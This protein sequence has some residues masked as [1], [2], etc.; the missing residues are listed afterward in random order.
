[1]A[2]VLGIPMDNDCGQQVETCHPVA[3]ALGGA[4]ADFG[5]SRDEASSLR[6]ARLSVNLAL[7]SGTKRLA[8]ARVEN[9]CNTIKDQ[10]D[11]FL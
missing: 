1:M 8:C 3:L 9:F 6:A 2:E 11:K 5:L 7:A 10:C 4:I